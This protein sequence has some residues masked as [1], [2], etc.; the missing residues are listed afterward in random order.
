ML[1]IRYSPKAKNAAL[2]VVTFGIFVAYHLA[3]VLPSCRGWG[4]RT[5]HNAGACNRS[6]IDGPS[7]SLSLYP[8]IYTKHHAKHT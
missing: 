7:Q 1:D 8:F 2:H 6:A 5:L 4:Q 3:T